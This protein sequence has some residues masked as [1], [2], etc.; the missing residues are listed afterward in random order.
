MKLVS[1]KLDPEEQAEQTPE[2]KEMEAPKYPYGSCLYLDETVLEMLGIKELPPVGTKFT[3]QAQAVV[4]GTSEREYEGGKH[5]TLDL[6]LT[7]LGMEAGKG[8]K[9]ADL[10][11]TAEKIYG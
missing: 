8:K 4:T 1:M 5:A 7:D 9:G 6:Q 10:K 11:E 2:A 3:I